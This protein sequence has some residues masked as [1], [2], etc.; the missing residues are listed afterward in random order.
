MERAVTRKHACRGPVNGRDRGVSLIELLVVLAILSVLTIGVG[1]SLTPR[2]GGSDAA[3]FRQAHERSRDLALHG[4]TR[5][6]LRLTATGLWLMEPTHPADGASGPLV[7]RQGAQLQDWHA[8]VGFRIA[9]PA[10]GGGQPN[11]L[12]LPNGQ[13]SAFEIWFR[14]PPLRCVTNGWEALQC[15]TE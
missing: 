13:T 14:D 4:E 6:G 3:A 15:Q 8:P 2:Q 7:W 5:R 1:L 12:Y 11:L 9:S 10:R